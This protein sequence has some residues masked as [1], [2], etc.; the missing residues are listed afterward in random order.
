MPF[1]P[2][3]QYDIFVSYAS[4]TNQDKWVTQFV[5]K[6]GKELEE[7]LG[8]SHFSAEKSIY[9]DTREIV[10]GQKFPDELRTAATQSALLI[11]VLSQGYLSSQWCES[12]R[13][14]FK[15]WLPEGALLP[16]CL[17]PL[18]V[19]PVVDALPPEFN[20]DNT[21][22]FSFLASK[23]DPY[24]SGSSEWTSKVKEFAGQ[25]YEKLKRLRLRCRPIYVGRSPDPL[26]GLQKRVFEHLETQSFRTT[27]D[28][29]TDLKLAVHFVGGSDGDEADQERLE[30]IERTVMKGV[31][32]F[33]FQPFASNLSSLEEAWRDDAKL[34]GKAVR[35]AT[36]WIERKDEQEL[37]NILK[38]ELTKLLVPTVNIGGT[39]LA[40]EPPD[41]PKAQALHAFLARTDC[42]ISEVEL[43]KAR[44]Q[45]SRSAFVRTPKVSCRAARAF[46]GGSVRRNFRLPEKETSVG[47]RQ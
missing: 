27:R 18:Q 45:A 24:S 17:A 35:A 34:T 12:E 30:A 3:C 4:E 10:A 25:V 19:R 43:R 13:I 41:E 8:R 1:V 44:T 28:C 11:A 20:R 40:C 16:E 46:A 23:Y 6:L 39:V 37:L 22:I 5:D 36:N 21:A 32:S 15:Q 14:A 42:R 2:G 26:F 31:T 38:N 9:F 7:L 47:R 33:V 29:D